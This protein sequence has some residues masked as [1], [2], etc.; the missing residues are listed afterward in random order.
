MMA[1][2]GLKELLGKLVLKGFKAL[3]VL[4]ATTALRGPRDLVEYLAK[5]ELLDLLDHKALKEILD[6]K[7]LLEQQELLDLLEQTVQTESMEV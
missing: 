4:T 5:Q 3:Q 1:L 6:H 7:V 2:K